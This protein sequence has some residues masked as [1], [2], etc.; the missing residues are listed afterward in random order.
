LKKGIE[1]INK[2][3]VQLGTELQTKTDAIDLFKNILDKQLTKGRSVDVL[4]VVSLYISCQFN[5][6]SVPLTFLSQ[7]SGI[8]KIKISKCYRAIRRKLQLKI[9]PPDLYKFLNYFSK[10]LNLSGEI[11]NT[12]EILISQILD[13]NIEQG[14]DP[15][16]VIGAVIYISGLICGKKYTQQKISDCLR[17]T[18]ATVRNRYQEI[19]RK[20]KLN[21]KKEIEKNKPPKV[22]ISTNRIIK[23][24]SNWKSLDIILKTLNIKNELDMR[25]VKIKLKIL[26]RKGIIMKKLIETKFYWKIKNTKDSLNV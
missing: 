20:L 15:C 21:Y 13:K 16:S 7:I 11:Y 4:I 12:A 25:F 14:K 2:Y 24:L 1:K 19:V 18:E 8:P 22:L 9:P 10:I 17:I 26:E 5:Q 6:E 23:I 3:S